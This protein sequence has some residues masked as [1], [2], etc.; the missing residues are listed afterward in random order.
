MPSI[1][2]RF[3]LLMPQ[4]TVYE[5]SARVCKLESCLIEHLQVGRWSCWNWNGGWTQ[6]EQVVQL[7]NAIL[8]EFWFNSS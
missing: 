1:C 7:G 2:H 6:L 5:L 3:G 8:L 4:E